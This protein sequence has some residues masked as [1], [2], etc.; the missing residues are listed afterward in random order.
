MGRGDRNGA[1]QRGGR[2]HAPRV[3][4]LD[5]SGTIVIGEGERDEAPMLYIG[6]KVGNP[7]AGHPR[8]TSRS[9]RSRARTSSPPAR[10]T[11]PRSSPRGAGRPDA[12]PRHVPEKLIVGPDGRR[13]RSTSTTRPRRPSR[14]S[15][16]ALGRNVWDITVVS[17][18]GRA[19]RISSTRCAPPGAHQAHLR[20][21][22][23]R[24]RSA[25][26]SRAPAC[27][28]SWASAARRKACSPRPRC[29]AW[30]ARSRRNFALA[31]RRGDGA[32]ARDGHR[33]RRR[34]VASTPPMTWPR[35]RTSSSAPPA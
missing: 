13:S 7:D 26:R 11:P 22:P 20:W 21:R 32:R 18:T 4:R 27:T 33:R 31:H 25:S 15:R 9:T 8:S 17:S 3:G 6:E 16:T 35:A 28:P 14:P 12:R 29:A 23:V 19:T 1:D 10:P 24:R 30:A 2:G 5:I 34:R